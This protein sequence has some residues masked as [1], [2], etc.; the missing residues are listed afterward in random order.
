MSFKKMLIILFAI[1]TLASTSF[2]AE[3]YKTDRAHSS[4]EFVVRHFMINKVRGEFKDFTATATYDAEDMSKWSVSATIQTA[5]ID[6]E[7]EKRDNHL[8]SPDFF[9]AE[10]NAEITFTSKSITKNGDEYV[11]VGDFTMRGVTKEIQLPFTITGKITDPWGNERI[12]IE[13][14]LT[15]NRQDYGVSWSKSMD[16]GGLVVSDEVKIELNMELVKK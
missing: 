4:V 2:A 11:A 15:I 1:Y 3:N 7:N 8:R 16:N 10:N 12:G 14:S 5:S 9:D 6:T 13:S